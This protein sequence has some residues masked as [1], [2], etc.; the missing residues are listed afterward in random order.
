MNRVIAC[1]LVAGATAAVAAQQV[2]K[3]EYPGIRNFSRVDATIACAGATSPEAMAGL[4]KEGFVSV[5][6]LR[7]ADEAGANVDESKAAAAAAGLKYFHL[8]FRPASPESDLV[9]RFI[10][11]VTEKTNQ[12]VLIHCGTANRVAALWMIKRV[13]VDGW[14]VEKALDEATAIGLT[15]EPLKKF[16]LD[17]LDKGVTP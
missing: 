2:E 3:Q 8:P 10:A 6:N 7:A 13:K 5:V 17:Y 12:P 14:P 15:S 4:K 9:D 1:L 11:T 16:A